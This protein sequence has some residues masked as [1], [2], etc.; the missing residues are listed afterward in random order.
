VGGG[1]TWNDSSI[2]VAVAIEEPP[3]PGGSGAR[4]TGVWVEA[5]TRVAVARK[6]DMVDNENENENV[7]S[8]GFS[9]YVNVLSNLNPAP[10][11]MTPSDLPTYM[12]LVP[13]ASSCQRYR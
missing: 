2:V 3:D 4:Q 12:Q 13:A 8:W 1:S 6:S 10:F 7:P 11:H 9:K 5:R